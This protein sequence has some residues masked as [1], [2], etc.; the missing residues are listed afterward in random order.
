MMSGMRPV[1][2]GLVGAEE[3]F[4]GIKRSRMAFLS[5]LA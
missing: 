4:G 1:V 3:W 2:K 5:V